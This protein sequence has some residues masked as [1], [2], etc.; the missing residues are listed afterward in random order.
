MTLRSRFK[1]LRGC[2]VA[3]GEGA[4]TRKAAPGVLAVLEMMD[5]AQSVWALAL[6]SGPRAMMVLAFEGIIKH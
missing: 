6:R 3:A 4:M 5:Q 1:G 2:R